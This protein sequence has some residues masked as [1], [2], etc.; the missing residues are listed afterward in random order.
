[1]PISAAFGGAHPFAL[2][3]EISDMKKMLVAA[4]VVS[5]LGLAASAFAHEAHV[6]GLARMNLLVEGQKVEIE[7]ATPLANLVSFEHEPETDAQRKEVRDMAAVMRKADALFVLPAEARCRLQEV[8]LES[9]AVSRE[10]LSREG[11]DHGRG[12]NA[13]HSSGEHGHGGLTAEISFMCSNPEKLNS[14]SVGMFGAFPG[15]QKIEVQVVTP[16]GQSAAVL[17]PGSAIIRW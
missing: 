12:H 5:V 9:D 16:K 8:S 1:L 6:H 3:P 10:L 15:T 13:G 17:T 14:I 7:L 4:V 11:A 2:E